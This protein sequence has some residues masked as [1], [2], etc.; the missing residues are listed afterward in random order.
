MK[1]I[2]IFILILCTTILS[3]QELPL[4]HFEVFGIGGMIRNTGKPV[5]PSNYS[6]QALV[7][8]DSKT[9]YGVTEEQRLPARG[10]GLIY[11]PSFLSY[12]RFS[13]GIG[14]QFLNFNSIVRVDSVVRLS[15]QTYPP[16]NA[17]SSRE[18]VK[19]IVWKV[20]QRQVQIPVLFRYHL[21]LKERHR[22]YAE[23]GLLIHAYRKGVY[24]AQLNQESEEFT[25]EMDLGLTCGLG[26]SFIYPLNR[27]NLLVSSAVV[28]GL[29]F[30]AT[31]IGQKNQ[32]FGFRIAAC[33]EFESQ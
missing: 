29:P 26:Y 9:Y 17:Y 27:I 24:P 30:S 7:G 13:T 23:T 8:Y 16:Q 22:F 20:N 31:V 3:A 12:K 25:G 18:V 4:N 19:G 33:I 10:I 32:F 5:S 1:S 15:G 2:S 14:L 6:Y 11:M 21:M 28:A